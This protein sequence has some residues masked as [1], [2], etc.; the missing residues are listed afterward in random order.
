MTKILKV[1]S[2]IFVQ[3]VINNKKLYKT[4]KKLFLFLFLFL[5]VFKATICM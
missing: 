3:K 1:A 2:I 4:N 5:E